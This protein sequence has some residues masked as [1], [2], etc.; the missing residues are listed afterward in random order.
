MGFH[1][2]G[3]RN[4]SAAGILQQIGWFTSGFDVEETHFGAR[5]EFFTRRSGVFEARESLMSK[6]PDASDPE[7]KDISRVGSQASR[8][9]QDQHVASLDE[10]LPTR[11]DARDRFSRILKGRGGRR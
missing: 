2:E 1:P 6:W 4:L 11:H 7:L 8:L 3:D 9:P 5:G 10:Q